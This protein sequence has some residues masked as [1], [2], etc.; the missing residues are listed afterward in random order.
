MAEEMLRVGGAL[1]MAALWPAALAFVVVAA[2]TFAWSQQRDAAWQFAL[3]FSAAYAAAHFVGAGDER[4]FVPA[5]TWHW[6]FYLALL[7]AAAGVVISWGIRTAI[8][9]CGVVAIV[10]ILSAVLLT[11]RSGLSLP[12]P[13]TIA[14]MVVYFVGVCSALRPFCRPGARPLLPLL[15]SLAAG[16]LAAMVTEQINVTH[17]QVLSSAAGS[18]LGVAIFALIFRSANAAAGLA[19]PFVITIGGWAWVEF[20]TESRL[21]PLLI[22]PAA[23]LVLWLAQFGSLA[24]LSGRISVAIQLG[25]VLAVVMAVGAYLHFAGGLAN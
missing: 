23:P 19:L 10:A 21:W 16:G 1:T 22:V 2:S 15:F 9:D 17:G 18:L 3:A 4:S 8:G 12:R 25:L 11:N 13:V 24:R 7:A 6:L 20:L 14:T 5:R